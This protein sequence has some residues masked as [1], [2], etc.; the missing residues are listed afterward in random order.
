MRSNTSLTS[1]APFDDVYR[2]GLQQKVHLH[3]MPSNSLSRTPHSIRLTHLTSTRQQQRLFRSPIVVIYSPVR[4]SMYHNN[5]FVCL[6]MTNI[7]HF[8]RFSNFFA[9]KLHN[10]FHSTKKKRLSAI[11]LRIILATPSDSVL[12]RYHRSDILT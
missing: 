10:S 5:I 3:Q 8:V 1:P 7:V 12:Q 6:R 11:F 2:F 4:F 9:A